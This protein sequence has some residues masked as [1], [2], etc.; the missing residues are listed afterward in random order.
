MKT[1][2]NRSFPQRLEN[3]HGN[4]AEIN[5]KDTTEVNERTLICR[6]ECALCLFVGI[7]MNFKILIQ[8][9]KGSWSMFQLLELWM[10]Y[11]V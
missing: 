10:V 8:G 7:S 3:P 1:S 5:R 6:G 2:F 9:S 4:I 11:F